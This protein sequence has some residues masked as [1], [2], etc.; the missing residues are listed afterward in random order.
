MECKK[1]RQQGGVDKCGPSVWVNLR[2]GSAKFVYCYMR[3]RRRGRDS[4][5]SE[6]SRAIRFG[7]NRD[8]LVLAELFKGR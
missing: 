7:R 2:E 5:V 1:A 6:V 4:S 3:G 8:V